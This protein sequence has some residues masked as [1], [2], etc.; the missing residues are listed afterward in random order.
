MP[1]PSAN[2]SASTHAVQPPWVG[3]AVYGSYESTTHV[4]LVLLYI[5]TF[6]G[7]S[8]SSST[9]LCLCQCFGHHQLNPWGWFATPYT[10]ALPNQHRLELGTLKTTRTLHEHLLRPIPHE[11]VVDLLRHSHLLP[12]VEVGHAPLGYCGVDHLQCAMQW[13]WQWG[14]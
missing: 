2:A 10:M 6:A 12:H 4:G 9:P 3:I 11:E 8:S 1:I 13:V 7:A 5:C 14:F